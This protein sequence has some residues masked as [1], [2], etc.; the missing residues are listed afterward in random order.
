[1]LVLLPPSECKTPARRGAAL[2]LE[3]LSFPGLTA[4]RERVLDALVD[5]AR[6]RPDT[7][8]AVL[9]LSERH[10]DEVVRDAGLLS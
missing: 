7:S 9:G 3:G 4:T 6:T 2:D 8:R 1:M 10:M 5:L